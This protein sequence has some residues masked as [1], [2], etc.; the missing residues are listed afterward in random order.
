M[1]K[2]API[3]QPVQKK[4]LFYYARVFIYKTSNILEVLIILLL[5]LIIFADKSILGGFTRQEIITYIIAGNLI[6]LISGYF[7]HRIIASDIYDQN[8]KLLVYKP[9]KYFF[10]ILPR[11]FGKNFLPFI[12]AV[13]FHLIVLY[14]FLDYFVI[15]FN[16]LHLSVIALMVILAFI[17]EFLLAYLL[18]LFVFWTFEA[19][20]PY[21]ILVRLKKF[22]AGAYFPLSLLSPVFVSVSLTLPFAYSFFVPMELYLEKIDLATGLRGMIV[23]IIWIVVIYAII[24]LTWSRQIKKKLEKQA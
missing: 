21:K 9:I 8:S 7:L 2:F 15:N 16:I 14:F 20:D 10:L 17:I 5:W 13:I 22:L 11:G 6:G 23:Q 18:N 1:F 4:G 3:D 19:K 24:Q 12:I